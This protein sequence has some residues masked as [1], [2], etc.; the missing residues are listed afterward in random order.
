[1]RRLGSTLLIVLLVGG[2]TE[3]TLSG[4]RPLDGP[5]PVATPSPAQL[6]AS[7]ARLAACNLAPP[8]EGG[9][10]VRLPDDPAVSLRLPPGF[11]RHSDDGDEMFH[12]WIDADSTFLMITV[13]PGGSFA[14]GINGEGEPTDEAECSARLA[15]RLSE[16]WR[17]RIDTTTPWGTVYMAGVNV[18]HQPDRF[19]GAGILAR[20]VEGRERALAALATLRVDEP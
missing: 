6:E 10:V 17:T 19:I 4:D 20:T 1:M 8:E 18:P 13:S 3:A 12:G 15:G 16:V 7:A 2:C 14:M 9:A 11:V 5:V